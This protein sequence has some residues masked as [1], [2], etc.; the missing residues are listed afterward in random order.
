M[1]QP[2]L[3]S[4]RRDAGHQLAQA[5]LTEL[6]QFNLSDYPSPIIYALPKGGL[7][8]AEPI[9]QIL[10][11]PVDLVVAKK[12]THPTNPELAI[13]AV[14][15]DGHLIRSR[16]EW[17]LPWSHGAWRSALEQARSQAEVQLADFA[18]YRPQVDPHGKLVLIVDDGIA[19]GMTTAVAVRTLRRQNPAQ[20]FIC[21][22]VAPKVRVTML[23]H[24]SDRV[25]VLATPD[26][27][28]S[29]SRFYEE[30]H[31]VEMEEAIACLQ[32]CNLTEP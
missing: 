24:W 17:V 22:P 28:L 7:P 27:F 18:A 30:F 1:P 23:E 16:Q 6:S 15:A 4:N 3:F 26:S 29:V 9:A 32:R 31:Q 21:A 5:I 13:G 2:Q 25:I 12:I 10:G 8:I 19:T 11:C 20:I 14:T